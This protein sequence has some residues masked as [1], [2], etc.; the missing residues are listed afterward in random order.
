VGLS[1]K[2][3]KKVNGFSLDVAWEIG[4]E[5]AVLFG[6]SGSGKSMSLQLVSGLSEPDAGFV[7]VNGKTYF[8]SSDGIYAPPQE[9]SIGYV[10]QDLALFPHMTVM[11]NIL[12]GAAGVPGREKLSRAREMIGAFRLT[13]LEDRYP[14]EIS[15]GQK[16]RV[17][18]ARALI[19]HPKALLLDEPFSALDNALR[20]EMRRFLHEVRGRFRIPVI[21]VTHD[22]DEAASLTERIIVYERGRVA[23]VGRAEQIKSSPVNRYVARLVSCGD[24]EENYVERRQMDP[25][26]DHGSLC[27]CSP[28]FN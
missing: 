7:R 15:G 1:V 27:D 5:L 2:L 23:Q 24:S 26:D 14:S 18:F 16:Q 19:R 21:L 12:F 11:K 13:G 8:D 20:R 28:I 10:F 9:R 6:C 17:A 4:D 22:F 3:K 25:S